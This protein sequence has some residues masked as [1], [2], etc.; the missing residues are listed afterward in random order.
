V[1]YECADNNFV[2]ILPAG[3]IVKFWCNCEIHEE[4]VLSIEDFHA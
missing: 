2:G 3:A 1:Q 4:R